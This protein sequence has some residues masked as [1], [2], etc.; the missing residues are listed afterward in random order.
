M[1]DLASGPRAVF[2]DAGNTLLRMDYASIARHLA[3]RG[4]A[5]SAERVEEAELVAR[6]RLDRDLAGGLSTESA[7]THDRYLRHVLAG[8]GIADEVE[9]AGIARWRRDFNRPVGL[10][11]LA[12]PDAAAVL[13]RVKARGLFVGVISN[14]NGMVRG[15]MEAAGL[16]RHLDVIIDSGAVGVEKP[17]PRI[18]HLALEA[19]GVP[20]A[21]AAYV[22]DLYSIDVVGARRAGL[23]AVLLDPGGHWGPRDC[24]VARGL[25]DAAR[26]LL[27][28]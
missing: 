23:D 28:E 12:D 11:Y 10:W 4:R 2:F 18:F 19:A 1:S 16:A 3:E 20:P 13:A 17:D 24:R 21:V 22:G 14:S 7:D 9:I 27:G 8:L 5:V 6:V 15:I 26:M 25:A